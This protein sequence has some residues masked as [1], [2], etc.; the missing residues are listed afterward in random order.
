M[1]LAGFAGLGYAAFR[2][3]GKSRICDAPQ[4]RGASQV[5]P[6]SSLIRQRERWKPAWRF[7]HDSPAAP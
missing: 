5:D 4:H 2:R 1:L 3:N 7:G 6:G